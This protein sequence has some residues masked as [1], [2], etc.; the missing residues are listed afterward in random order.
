MTR[1]RCF[2]LL[3]WLVT[4]RTLD[5][6][7]LILLCWESDWVARRRWPITDDQLELIRAGWSWYR[8]KRAYQLV[9]RSLH[10]SPVATPPFPSTPPLPTVY[11]SLIEF[12]A[13]SQCCREKSV[14]RERDRKKENEGIR[15]ER[16]LRCAIAGVTL[17]SG[18]LFQSSLTTWLEREAIVRSTGLGTVRI[19][20][21]I[22]WYLV[23]LY[24]LCSFG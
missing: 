24:N 2:S 1:P 3:S 16:T 15:R 18:R 19:V 13:R 17:W 11:T 21:L 23:Q 8:W 9:A 5:G 6:R 7:V 20:Q 14:F 12:C 10:D 4:S 22:S